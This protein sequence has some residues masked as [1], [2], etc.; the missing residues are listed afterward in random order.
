M[1]EHRIASSA[2]APFRVSPVLLSHGSQAADGR[3][4]PQF[5][6]PAGKVLKPGVTYRVYAQWA[7]I[8]VKR[9][10]A[11]EIAPFSLQ[12]AKAMDEKSFELQIRND[13]Q[14]DLLAGRSVGLKG[15]D[16]ST[17]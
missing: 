4:A 13:P 2:T 11:S 9:F 7:E 17:L 8:D 10:V 15:S 5:R 14:S 16:G 6:L 3:Q 1:G 12:S